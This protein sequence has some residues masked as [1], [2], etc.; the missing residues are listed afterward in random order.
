MSHFL[1]I[2][3]AGLGSGAVYALVALGFS[4][5]YKAARA[6]NF[7]QGEI[8][9]TAGVVASTLQGR[10]GLP[11]VA[12]CVVVIVGGALVGIGT[13]LIAVRVL[14]RPDHL[15]ITLG[16]VGVAI[17][18][19]SI[20]LLRTHGISYSLPAFSGDKPLHVGGALL[21]PQTIWNLAIALVCVTAL[22]VFFARTRRGV[23]LRA[24]AADRDTA[25]AFGVSVTRA[26]TW[27][28][29]LAG[30][31]AATAG[32]AITPVTLMSFDQGTEVGLIG[33]AA[34]M[35]GGLGSMPGAVVGGLV[36]GVAENLV[37]GY[38][39]GTYASATGFVILLVVLFLRPGGLFKATV[40]ERV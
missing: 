1:Q 17:A 5:V 10:F 4:I 29:G 3:F 20:V 32:V 12:A 30:A 25:A 27:A 15:T 28:F 19:K 18:L 33:F 21:S 7:A 24:S 26:T 31:L 37:G 2:L 22:T 9:M 40:D 38:W 36:V 39:T 16:T 14:G 8:L 23:S 13:D 35:L 6:I 11:L 34:A